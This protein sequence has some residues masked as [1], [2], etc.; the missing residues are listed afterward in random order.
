MALKMKHSEHILDLSVVQLCPSVS[1]AAYYVR[2]TSLPII[3]ENVLK[4]CIFMTH[5]LRNSSSTNFH[6]A[7]KQRWIA[8]SLSII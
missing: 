7:F 2:E 3:S 8:N 6:G 4:D 5:L 1:Q